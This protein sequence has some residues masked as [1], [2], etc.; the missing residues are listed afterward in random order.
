LDAFLRSNKNKGREEKK[1]SVV[2]CVCMERQVIGGK[3]VR[4]KECRGCS[5]R[6]RS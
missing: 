6:L 2:V 1:K 4:R 5:Q 3:N